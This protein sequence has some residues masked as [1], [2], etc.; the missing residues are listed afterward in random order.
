[1]S[2]QSNAVALELGFVVAFACLRRTEQNLN[3]SFPG[4]KVKWPNVRGAGQL[5]RGMEDVG[6][7]IVKGKLMCVPT[8]CQAR[9]RHF[10]I[11]LALMYPTL[12]RQVC[13]SQLYR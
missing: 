13:S 11:L 7:S 5:I 9:V 2:S 10:C 4:K 6:G 8:V 12:L 1:M 3:Y